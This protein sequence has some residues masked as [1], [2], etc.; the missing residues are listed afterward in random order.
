VRLLGLEIT[1][2]PRAAVQKA[3]EPA[4]QRSWFRIFES[5]AGAWQQNVVVD[6]DTVL[7]YSAV[8][9]CTTL[10]AQDIGK[11][12]VKLMQQNAAG[13]WTETTSPAFSPLLR[14][15][16]HFQNRIK[17]LEQWIASK[18][19]HGN[20]YVLKARDSRGVVVAMYVLD[21]T[22]VL[23][24][25]S[26]DGSVFYELKTDRLAS[27]ETQVVVPA[28]EIIH[29][30]MVPLF[31]PLVGV[32]PIYACGIAAM[33]GV[34]IQRNSSAFFA[35]Q[36]QPGGILTAPGSISDATAA[37]LKT[38]WEENFTGENAGRVAVVGDGLKYER[39]TVNAVDAQLIDQLKFSAETVCSTFHVP[40][41]MIGVG[42]MPAYNNIEALNQQYYSQCLQ[43]LIESLELSLDEGLGLVA[44]SGSYGTELDL[45]GLLRMDTATRF[46]SHSD[47]IAGGW[48]APNEARRKEDF[49]PVKGGETPYLQQ[50][51]YSLAALAAR[52][53]K[54]QTEGADVQTSV[55]NGGQVSAL[56]ALL[57]AVASGQLPA[58]SG[59]AA[60]AAAFPALSTAEIDTMVDPL[61]EFEPDAPD[62]P[63]GPPGGP[64]VD[65]AADP[66]AQDPE[67]AADLADLAKHLGAALDAR[68]M[69]AA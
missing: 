45:D 59:K 30:P 57:T 31:H 25:V 58:E 16:N 26:D 36:S 2:A 4:D 18:L 20:A 35:N 10:I 13:L 61:E 41:Y 19:M 52:D 66:A 21:P 47:A 44:A 32:T 48:L 51:N 40:P 29:D 27:L 7:S 38:H 69:R 42:P 9:A 60:I 11:L 17:F 49:A 24:L 3:M 39:L 65:P 34:N 6:R 46:K 56:Q 5:F 15:P 53:V 28:R 54:A 50:Q 33:Q 14:K 64:P 63:T 68:R 22:R 55:M 62:P 12:R 67:D 8:F 1:R 43:S 23:P 37:R